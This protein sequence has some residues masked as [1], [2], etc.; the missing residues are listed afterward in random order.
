VDN[1]DDQQ[2]K[3]S[4]T[5]RTQKL[6]GELK[7]RK[8][9]Q[10]TSFYLVA[11]WG[12]SAGAAD[13]FEVLDF[14]NWAS[15]YFVIALFSFTPVV[16]VIA[17]VFELNRAGIQRDHG[18]QRLFVSTTDQTTILAKGNVPVLTATWQG[19]KRRFNSDFVVGRDDSCGLQLV[20]PMIS[21]QHAQIEYEKN[22]WRVRDLGSSNGIIVNGEKVEE[23][24]LGENS[25][26]QFYPNGP[27]LTLSV[28]DQVDAVTRMA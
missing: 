20:D 10:V 6:I 7:R 13:I 25:H 3:D 17:W 4:F 14:P 27:E 26:L 12:L 16:I 5:K 1:T 9:F 19:K 23:A 21:R 28:G 15:R 8:V 11:A 2:Q 24:A 18:P 22:E